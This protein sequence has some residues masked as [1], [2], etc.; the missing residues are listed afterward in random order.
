MQQYNYN[1]QHPFA[2]S[3]H[4]WHG[5]VKKMDNAQSSHF[6]KGVYFQETDVVLNKQKCIDLSYIMYYSINVFVLA[7]RVVVYIVRFC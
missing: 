1:I 3:D 2:A 6:V 5:R 4:Q 7:E